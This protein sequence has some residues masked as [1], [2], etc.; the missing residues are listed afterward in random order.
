[1]P[2]LSD[3]MD[4]W[5]TDF[6]K[7]VDDC[8]P[9]FIFSSMVSLDCV[10]RKV[11]LS[12]C[13]MTLGLLSRLFMKGCCLD[14]S[15]TGSYAL[16]QG[17]DMTYVKVPLNLIQMSSD[18]VNGKVIVGVWSVL[19]IKGIDVILGND[20]AGGKVFLVLVVKD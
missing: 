19:H 9:P 3:G 5:K 13:C 2:S 12:L 6:H 8:Y 16:C 1:M 10:I 15:I 4:L 11:S 18:L 7:I 20:F 14:E 17:L